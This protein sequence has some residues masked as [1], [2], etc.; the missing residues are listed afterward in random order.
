MQVLVVCKVEKHDAARQS[1]VQLSANSEG[2][3][4]NQPHTAGSSIM[5]A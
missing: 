5:L 3:R 2:E 4:A 1:D